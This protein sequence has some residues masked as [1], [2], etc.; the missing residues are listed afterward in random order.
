MEVWHLSL[1]PSTRDVTVSVTHSL[2]P[3]FSLLLKS[4]LAMTRVVPAY[5]LSRKNEDLKFGL[6]FL[7]LSLCLSLPPFLSFYLF[8]FPPPSLSLFFVFSYVISSG[9]PESEFEASKGKG[10]SGT[11]AIHHTQTDRKRKGEYNNMIPQKERETQ[12]GHNNYTQ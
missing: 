11:P 12:S 10:P 6:V 2:Y 7:S 3:R 1:D 4:L 8:P 5:Q 9:N